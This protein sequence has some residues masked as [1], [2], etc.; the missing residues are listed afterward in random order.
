MTATL[1]SADRLQGVPEE[2]RRSLANE[3]REIADTIERAKQTADVSIGFEQWADESHFAVSD[4]PGVAA[5]ALMF[6]PKEATVE[7]TVKWSRS[8]E[9]ARR[10]SRGRRVRRKK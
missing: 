3:L 2:T 9:S 6:S 4:V 8:A 10:R 1:V 5:Y 7:I